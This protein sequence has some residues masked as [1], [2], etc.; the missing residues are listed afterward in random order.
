MR[1]RFQVDENTNRDELRLSN[2]DEQ[3]SNA[4]FYRRWSNFGDERRWSNPTVLSLFIEY[5]SSSIPST[6]SSTKPSTASSSKSIC[7]QVQRKGSSIFSTCC[8]VLVL[9]PNLPEE[10]DRRRTEFYRRFW[11]RKLEPGF[12]GLPDFCNGSFRMQNLEMDL[13]KVGKS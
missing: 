2:E 10:D 1:L 9:S 5:P 13:R 11:T 7:L 4:V 8:P 6:S 12:S 3:C